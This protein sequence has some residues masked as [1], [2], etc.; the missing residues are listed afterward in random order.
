VF[1]DW[2]KCGGWENGQGICPLCN[3][4]VNRCQSDIR[5]HRFG[6]TNFENEA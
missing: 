3:N 2:T 4:G 6:G 1:R 5:E